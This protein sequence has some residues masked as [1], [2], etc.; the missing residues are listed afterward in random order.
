MQHAILRQAL[1]MAVFIVLLALFSIIL[2]NQL[3]KK[4]SKP[5]LEMAGASDKISRGEAYNH[6]ITRKRQDEI[7]VLYDSFNLMM[8]TIKHREK[9]LGDKEQEF[10]NAGHIIPFFSDGC[11]F[12]A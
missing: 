2:A 8:D 4:I 6:K 1:L 7:G 11:Q 3:Q 9:D 12:R 10:H 5:I